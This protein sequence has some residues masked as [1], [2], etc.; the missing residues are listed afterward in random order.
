MNAKIFFSA[1]AII[2]VLLIALSLVWPQGLGVR[3]PA[4]FGHAIE[5]PD[6]YRMDRERTERQQHEAAQ[7][8]EDARTKAA[9]Q[10]AKAAREGTSSDS[11]SASSS[12]SST[13]SL[14]LRK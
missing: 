1:S 14:A 13:A 6:W 2:A 8:A 3:S 10:A 11:A 12:S 5:M 7:K 4:P 9:I